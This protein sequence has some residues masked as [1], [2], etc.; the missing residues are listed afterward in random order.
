MYFNCGRNGHLESLFIATPE[1][2]EFMIGKE[3]YFGEVLGKHS[4]IYGKLYRSE[5]TFITNDPAAIEIFITHDLKIGYCP[6]DALEHG[7]ESY[8]YDEEM[9]DKDSEEYKEFEEFKKLFN[10]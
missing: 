5:I 2:V 7:Y 9:F 3:L 6:I 4:E 1:Q 10:R 8:E